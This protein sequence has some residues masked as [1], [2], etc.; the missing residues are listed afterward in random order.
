[1]AIELPEIGARGWGVTLNEALTALDDHATGD[2]AELTKVKG[3]ST[4]LRN[5][6]GYK[7]PASLCPTTKAV[8]SVTNNV[9][10]G[11]DYNGSTYKVQQL[12]DVAEVNYV[13]AD[14][15]QVTALNTYWYTM[16]S[17]PWNSGSETG[18]GTITKPYDFTTMVEGSYVSFGYSFMAGVWQPDVRIWIDDEEIS[19]WYLGARSGGTLQGKS[20]INA[21]ALSTG[22]HIINVNFPKRGLYKVRVA[23][24][25]NTVGTV[26]G[27]ASSQ[28][29]LITV[30][31][32]TRV[33]KPAPRLNIGVISDS[34]FEPIIGQTCLSIAHEIG[35]H[36][37][38]NVWNF[39]Q[40]GSGFVNPSG[41]GVNGDKSYGSALV[42]DTLD[43][44]PM[45]DLLIVNGSANDL[46]YSD[47]QVQAAMEA[48]FDMIRDYNSDIPVVWVGVEPQSY[49]KN[50][51]TLPTMKA[52]E[53]FQLGIA[54]AD[55]NVVATIPTC[56]EEWLTGTGRVGAT[57]GNGN[58]DYCTG[59]DGVHLSE[60][61]TVYY[62]KMIAE[63]M[64]SALATIEV[65]P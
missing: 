58:Q 38:A 17:G 25:I 33:L 2:T 19:D 36:L 34:W 32:N 14:L 64:K 52:R 48:T 35:H 44:H 43:R 3:L 49:F 51:Y 1:M 4:R 39:A 45:M 59:A 22:I 8:V 41:G 24:M 50:I 28:G 62:G 47:A 20:R 13:A 57:T 10:D 54:A 46:P 40:G 63:R 27:V 56:N 37:N 11:H 55:P 30:N 60:Y 9:F 61:G 18:N 31:A 29:N 42:R 5:V 6:G 65:G 26:G 15:Y 7:A 16:H 23:G 21:A 12:P 53:T